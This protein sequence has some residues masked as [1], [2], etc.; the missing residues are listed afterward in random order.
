MAKTVTVVN[1]IE[2]QNTAVTIPFP[3]ESVISGK[4]RSTM[5]VNIPKVNK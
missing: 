3:V 5:K 4:G 2:V 1:T